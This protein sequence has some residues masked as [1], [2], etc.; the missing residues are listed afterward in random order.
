MTRRARGMTLIELIVFIVIVSVALVGVL[1][2]FNTAVRSSAD[3]LVR[4][5]ALVVAE[6]MMQE[7][8]QKSFQNDATGNNAATPTLGCTPTTT[9][10]CRT[11]TAVD[12]PN[13]NDVDDYQGYSQTGITQID[14]TTAV[15]GLGSYTISVSVAATAL[16]TSNPVSSANAKLISVTVSGPSESIT[17]TSYRTNYE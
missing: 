5:Q 15:S 8:L 6:A 4:K 11:N 3:P 1:S 2:V 7:I 10:S 14:G 12:R 9:P 16:G 13:Y 17:L